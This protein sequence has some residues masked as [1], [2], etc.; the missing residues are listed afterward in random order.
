MLPEIH[1]KC[2]KDTF[3]EMTAPVNRFFIVHD[4]AKNAIVVTLAALTDAILLFQLGYWVIF[5][6]SWR[7]PIAVTCLYLLRLFLIVRPTP[8]TLIL[9]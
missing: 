2:L 3:F 1:V 8:P 5:G 4:T 7:Y 6:K 9:R